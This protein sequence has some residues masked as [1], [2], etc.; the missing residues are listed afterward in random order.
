[1]IV[2][3]GLDLVAVS[4]FAELLAPPSAFE[5]EHFTEQERR[6]ATAGHGS[7]EQHLAARWAAKE[8]ALKALDHAAAAAGVTPPEVPAVSVEVT[9]DGRGRPGLRL[10]DAAASLA[11][12]VGADRALVTLSHDGDHAVAVVVLERL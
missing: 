11:E 5:R 7:R 12:R 8:A 3:M 2:G 10:H 1:M 9:R 6:Y 4:G